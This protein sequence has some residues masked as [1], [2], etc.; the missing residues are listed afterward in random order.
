MHYLLLVEVFDDGDT[1]NL[2]L[3]ALRGNG[4]GPSQIQTIN[5]RM[6]GPILNTKSVVVVLGNVG[7]FT[8]VVW[9]K[10]LEAQEF[11]FV[12]LLEFIDEVLGRNPLYGK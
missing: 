7:V 11:L 2:A 8:F 10:S 3:Y 6:S 12:L 4:N 9:V 5:R 1:V